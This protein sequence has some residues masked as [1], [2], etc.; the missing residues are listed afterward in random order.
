MVGKASGSRGFLRELKAMR[1]LK[2]ELNGLHFGTG[3]LT[4][5]YFSRV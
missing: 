1:D 3:Q 2:A 4:L 5:T